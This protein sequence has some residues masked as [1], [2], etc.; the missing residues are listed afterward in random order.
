LVFLLSATRPLDPQI[1]CGSTASL[2][3]A[4]PIRGLQARACLRAAAA[5]S[6]VLLRKRTATQSGNAHM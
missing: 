1:A 3:V 5:C 6:L 4:A 2:L